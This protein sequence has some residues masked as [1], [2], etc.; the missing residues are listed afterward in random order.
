MSSSL[1][2]HRC[3]LR[4]AI[5]Q[6]SEELRLFSMSR[7]VA[8]LDN[9][10]I[11]KVCIDFKG[12]T[13]PPPVNINVLTNSDVLNETIKSDVFTFL[14]ISLM[15]DLIRNSWIPPSASAFNLSWYQM[16]GRRWKVTFYTP[17]RMGM[18][19]RVSYF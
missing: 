17:E 13:L 1:F 16:S 5:I 11:I 3:S 4:S 8:I 15:F 6:D 7:H 12:A 10:S 19:G 9:K 18:R 14:P 2:T